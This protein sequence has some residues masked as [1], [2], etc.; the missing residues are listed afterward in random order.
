MKL[1]IRAVVLFSFAILSAGCATNLYPGGPTPGGLIFS[2]TKSTAP[3]LAAHVDMNIRPIKNG[4]STSTAI[5]GLFA[6]GDSS[7][8]AAMKAAGITTLN[9]VDYENT[10]VLGS[11]FIS[12][13]TIVYGE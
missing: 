1:F 10:T 2:N 3:A 13:T 6:F 11:L 4:S 8:T 7:V 12:T 9:H 5:L